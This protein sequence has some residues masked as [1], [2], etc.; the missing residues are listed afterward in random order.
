M[1]WQIFSQDQVESLHDSALGLLESSGV[2]VLSERARGRYRAAGCRIDAATAMVHIDR[3]LVATALASAPKSISLRARG[4]HRSVLLDEQSLTFGPVSGPP[5]VALA[6]ARGGGRVGCRTTP[7]A[8][9]S[10]RA[11]M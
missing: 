9:V 6:D 5:N 8:S 11:L 1:P 2:K 4:E 10:V 3:E 7:T